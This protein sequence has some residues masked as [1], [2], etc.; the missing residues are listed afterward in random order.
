[1][2]TSES[3]QLKDHVMVPAGTGITSP[4]LTV[5]TFSC[6]LFGDTIPHV[7]VPAA[8]LK[9]IE[10]HFNITNLLYGLNPNNINI[11]ATNMRLNYLQQ[12]NKS[13]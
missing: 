9:E 7:H 12:Y 2:V 1:M 6:G 3:Q 10:H 4:L 8:E 11:F 5:R 13:C